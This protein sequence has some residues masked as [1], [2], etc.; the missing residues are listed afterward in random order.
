M[1]SAIRY[2]KPRPTVVTRA[3]YMV[4]TAMYDAWSLYDPLA[5]PTVLDAS[6]RRPEYEQSYAN[7]AAAVSQAAYQMLIALFP[8]YEHQS[9]AFATLLD[10]LDYQPVADGSSLTP[11]G[12]GYMAAQAV[13]LSRA[14]D[15]SNAANNYADMVSATYRNCMPPLTAL[16]TMH[17]MAW[18]NRNLIRPGGNPC[19]FP[20]AIFSM[21][22]GFRLL[23]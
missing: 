12:I 7:K 3:M 8:D 18:A 10:N 20:P 19:G 4:H 13:L 1:L 21:P 22:V 16:I 15:G 17:L 11:A 9:Q 14:D 6:L 23:I 2:G 5:R